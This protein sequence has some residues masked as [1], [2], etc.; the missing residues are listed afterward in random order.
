LSTE[1]LLHG[2]PAPRSSSAMRKPAN[3]RIQPPARRARRG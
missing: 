1:G 3:K 2:A